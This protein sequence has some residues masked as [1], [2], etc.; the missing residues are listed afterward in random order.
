M[1]T[2]ID[3][4]KAKKEKRKITM[5]STYDYWSALICEE[6]GVDCILV[7]DSLGMVIQGQDS[8]LP[9]SL[10]EMIY[11]GKAVRKGAPNTFIVIDMPFLTYQVSKEEALKNAGRIM[12]ETGANAVKIE[13]GE[14]ILDTVEKLVNSGI[15]VM[16]H[17]GLTPQSVHTLGGYRVQGKTKEKQEK[18]KRNARLLQEAGVFSIVL[19]A[20]PQKLA[21]E[22]TKSLDIPTIGIGAGNKTD[23]Q[24]LV[25]HDLLGFFDKSPKFVKRY[26]EGKKL[27][28]DAI[29]EFIKEVKEGT[30]PEE[31]HTYL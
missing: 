17:L 16:G 8:T 13:G 2:I 12:K 19:E 6:V 21:E 7:G 10:D 25:F 28:K 23:G 26:L 18:I 11:H 9:V 1:K 30:F 27:F 4:F 14:E 5:I 24:V 20:V 3:F 15:P 31:K 29:N 22:I